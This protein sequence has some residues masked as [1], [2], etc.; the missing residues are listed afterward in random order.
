M[1]YH[2]DI[3]I[4]KELSAMKYASI[5]SPFRGLWLACGLLWALAATRGLW[6][7]DYAHALP[8]DRSLAEVIALGER[9]ARDV[10]RSLPS[11]PRSAQA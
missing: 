8:E 3:P 11:G 5:R 2:G 6:A 4:R 10:L 1:R 9:I 7:A